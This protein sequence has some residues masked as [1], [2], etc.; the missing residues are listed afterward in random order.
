VPKK[1]LFV[2][3]ERDCLKVIGSWIKSWGY[4]VIAVQ[5]GKEALDIL[6]AEKVDAILLDYLMPDIDGI[7]LLK[8]IRAMDGEIPVIMFTAY[9]EKEAMQE[10]GKLNVSAFVPKLS[11]YTDSTNIL[12][13]S[14][15]VKSRC[16]LW[17]LPMI[18][19][20]GSVSLSNLSVL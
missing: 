8:K 15:L 19:L 1:V 3:D 2:D 4:E 7:S 9:P 13:I 14:S 12:K 11:S 17:V 10:A 18:V 16:F 6:A 5:A 20:R